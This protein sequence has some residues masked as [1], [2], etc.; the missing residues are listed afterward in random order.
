MILPTVLLPYKA[1]IAE[2]YITFNSLTTKAFYSIDF[3]SFLK[4][5]EFMN[6]MYS[7]TLFIRTPSFPKKFPDKRGFRI[8]ES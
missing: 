6:Y 8:Y 7:E 2:K 3:F 5:L 1:D 4:Q